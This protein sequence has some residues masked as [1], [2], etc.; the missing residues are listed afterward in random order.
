M[1]SYKYTKNTMMMTHP[2]I[3]PFESDVLEHLF[4]INGNGFVWKNGQLIDLE[5]K[6]RKQQLKEARIFVRKRNEI[7][8]L[9]AIEY[10]ELYKHMESYS[11]K[12]E[13]M[14]SIK[15]RMNCVNNG[16]TFYL[17]KDGLLGR[18]IYP[19]CEYAK[20]VN[21]PN[22]VK[23]DWLKAA[24]LMLK[25]ARSQLFKCTEEDLKWLKK[26]EDNINN[27]KKKRDIK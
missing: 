14:K 6:S 23:P 2:G 11:V 16:T 3:F 7:L 25:L 18:K 5:L 10:Q 12:K 8:K 24:E 17:T 13:R 26:A 19:L 4:V 20:I 21:I 1:S 27:I 22:D 15:Y 9:A